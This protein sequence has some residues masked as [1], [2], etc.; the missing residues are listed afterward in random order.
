[1]TLD[2]MRKS[3]ETNV[4][5]YWYDMDLMVKEFYELNKNPRVDIGPTVF[6]HF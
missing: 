4:D 5:D 3:L 1:M 6:D 2:I